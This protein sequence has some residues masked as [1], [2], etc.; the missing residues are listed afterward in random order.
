MTDEHDGLTA[1][2][3]IVII[4][5]PT[6]VEKPPERLIEE[7]RERIAILERDLRYAEERAYRAEEGQNRLLEVCEANRV[8]YMETA[9]TGREAFETCISIL[10]DKL[11]RHE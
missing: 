6:Y 7:L 5:N 1:E 4:G 10:A 9:K 2:D 8:F 3:G 11:G